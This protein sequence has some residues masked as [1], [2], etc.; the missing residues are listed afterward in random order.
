MH[1]ASTRPG[2]IFG[3]KEKLKDYFL[4]SISVGKSTSGPYPLTREKVVSMINPLFQFHKLNNGG[5]Q[6]ANAIADTFDILLTTLSSL[7]PTQTREFSIV[8]TKLEEAC[9]FAKKSMA[10]DSS[11]QE[12]D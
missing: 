1:K 9:F 6:K 8:K 5:I 12:A 3:I 10:A 2:G 4:R 7:C 11:N